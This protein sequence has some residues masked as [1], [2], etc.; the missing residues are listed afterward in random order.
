MDSQKVDMYIMSNAKYFKS[1]QLNYIR[2]R[3]LVMDDSKWGM[4]QS[5][6]LKDPTTILIVSILAGGLGIDRFMI[7]DAGLG[8]AKLLTCGGLGIWA[9]VDLFLIMDATRDK[10]MEKVQQFLV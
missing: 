7:G 6:E 10:N 4:I 8:V 2:E 5:V 1:Q 9:I 3:L